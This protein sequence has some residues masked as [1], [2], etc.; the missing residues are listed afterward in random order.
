MGQAFCMALPE[1]GRVFI[2]AK[3][4]G[5]RWSGETTIM[6]GDEVMLLKQSL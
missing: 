4:F 3:G 2:E 5:R 6:G 1:R